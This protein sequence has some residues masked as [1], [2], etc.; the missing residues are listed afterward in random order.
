[1]S[2][3]EIRALVKETVSDVLQEKSKSAPWSTTGR[4]SFTC[5]KLLS[6]ARGIALHILAGS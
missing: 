2:T 4:E 3:N 1:M 5:S 6:L